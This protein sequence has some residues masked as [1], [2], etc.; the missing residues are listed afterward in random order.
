MLHFA[1]I[2]RRSYF[3]MHNLA[4]SPAT[5]RDV[6]RVA[7]LSVASV[8]RVLNGH[9]NVHPDTRQRVLDAVNLLGYAPNAAARSLSTARTH[10]IGVV[11]PDLYGE[12][13]GELVRG[14][15]RV[16][17]ERGYLLLLSNMHADSTLAGQAMGAMRGRVDGL[18]VM[19]P[20]IAARDL[21]KAL[22]VGIPTVLVNSPEE[23]GLHALKVD[24]H[25][26]V[27]AMVSHL[28]QT[29][30]KHIIHLAGI[31]GNIDGAERKQAYLD[32]MADLA[33]D[34]PVR[35]LDGDFT[36]A[37]GEALVAELLAEDARFDAIFAANDMMALGVLLALREARIDVPGQ[38]AVAGYDDVP[39]ARYLSLSTVRCDMVGMGALAIERLVDEIEKKGTGPA[40][41]L[42][43]P[44]LIVRT[45]TVNG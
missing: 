26:G 29:G 12:F 16:A 34:L 5:I 44:E 30:R 6:A 4:N 38:V 9:S 33:P 20:Q 10:A 3:W 42:L 18:I 13:F 25:K 45:T 19:A 11:L 27:R 40:L 39:L 1:I 32:A 17:S 22:P 15:D 28:L 23:G 8:S 24:N 36:E 41:E 31:V 43:E 35:V 37:S 14:M 7:K 2:L 21:E